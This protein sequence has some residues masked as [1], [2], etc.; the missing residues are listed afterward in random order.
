METPNKI[1]C[2]TNGNWNIS[3]SNQTFPN[4]QEYIR[5]KDI[6]EWLDE[7]WHVANGFADATRDTIHLGMANAFRM[8][9]EYIEQ[10]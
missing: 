6:L 4:A 9:K 8:A 5:K 3:Y 2:G 7:R 10:M 1:F